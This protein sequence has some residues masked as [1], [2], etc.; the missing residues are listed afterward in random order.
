MSEHTIRKMTVL[1]YPNS[2]ETTA[3]MEWLKAE[4]DPI[5]RQRRTFIGELTEVEP[6]GY[7]L[8]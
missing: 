7:W 4:A 6:N 3:L 2:N 5:L 8:V 1:A